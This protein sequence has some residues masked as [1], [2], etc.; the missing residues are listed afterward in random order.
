MTGEPF[1]YTQMNVYTDL[2]AGYLST[3]AVMAERCARANFIMA[4]SREKYVAEIQKEL[5]TLLLVSRLAKR[6]L[7]CKDG[8]EQLRQED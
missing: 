8:M 5:Q 3:D 7:L 4:S 1:G 6:N 2:N